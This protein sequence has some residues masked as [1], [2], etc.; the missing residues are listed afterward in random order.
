MKVVIGFLVEQCPNDFKLHPMSPII[1]LSLP[2]KFHN[3]LNY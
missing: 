2:K 1:I 3:F